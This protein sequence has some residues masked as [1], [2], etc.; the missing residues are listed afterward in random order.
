MKLKKNAKNRAANAILEYA[1]TLTIVSLVFAGMHVYLKRGMQAKL[2]GMTDYFISDEQLVELDPTTSS[3]N[4]QTDTYA[5]RRR[6]K[7][8]GT[9]RETFSTENIVQEGEVITE[10][11]IDVPGNPSVPGGHSGVQPYAANPSGGLPGQNSP[12]Q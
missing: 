3:Q 10:D 1:L 12:T 8:G 7:G 11:E 4:R 9:R 6:F 2:K 5:G